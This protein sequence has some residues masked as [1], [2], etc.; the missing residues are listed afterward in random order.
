MVLNIRPV[1][2]GGAGAA[3]ASYDYFDIAEG[4]GT[5]EFT[6]FFYGNRGES[7]GSLIA[8]G[9]IDRTKKSQSDSG[10]CAPAGWSKTL[11]IDFDLAQFNTPKTIKGTGYF[12]GSWMLEDAS[13]G[14]KT[15]GAIVIK[16]K[17]WDGTTETTIAQTSG[18]ITYIAVSSQNIIPEIFKINIPSADF[19]I[20]EV[21]RVSAEAWYESASNETKI[22]EH[23]YHNPGEKDCSGAFK[24]LIPFKLEV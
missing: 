22:Q 18:A 8:D 24:I 16:I 6:G 17:K 19:K 20:G 3:V 14:T 13:T 1:V 10:P 7:S 12:L 21:L 23:I 2:T 9:V 4:T 15:S 11:D 5:K